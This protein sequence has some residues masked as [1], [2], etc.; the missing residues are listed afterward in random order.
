MKKKPMTVQEAGKRGGILRA[1]KI[2]KAEC[3]RIARIASEAAKLARAQK[4]AL[5]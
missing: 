1:E 4:K 2:G 3:L 5:S